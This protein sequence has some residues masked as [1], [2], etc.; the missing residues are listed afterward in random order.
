M[1][2]L[3]HGGFHDTLITVGHTDWKLLT[4][5]QIAVLEIATVVGILTFLF[6]Q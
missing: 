4:I 2:R 3:K 1:T 6:F 5:G